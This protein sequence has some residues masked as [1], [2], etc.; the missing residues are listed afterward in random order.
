MMPLQVKLSRKKKCKTRNTQTK[1]GHRRKAI[2]EI[3]NKVTEM[4]SNLMTNRLLENVDAILNANV[5]K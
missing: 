3:N 2:V 5:G 4:L 1:Q